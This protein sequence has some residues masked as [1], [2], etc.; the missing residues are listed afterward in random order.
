MLRFCRAPSIAKPMVN[1]APRV[2]QPRPCDHWVES[3]DS[4]SSLRAANAGE[5]RRRLSRLRCSLTVRAAQTSCPI[6]CCGLVQLFFCLPSVT[7]Q[8][9]HCH[10]RRGERLAV[11]AR[12][13]RL[14][15]IQLS[16]PLP[17]HL[18]VVCP[19]LKVRRPFCARRILRCA[20]FR[21]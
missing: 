12:F 16:S 2:H 11:I 10:F 5:T 15:S 20:H 18:C 3:N 21:S 9:V 13:W 4:T 1:Y 14:A 8:A 17:A 6:S 7:W 19:C